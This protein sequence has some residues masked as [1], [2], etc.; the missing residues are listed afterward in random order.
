MSTIT[1]SRDVDG[2]KD[3]VTITLATSET[4]F[5]RRSVLIFV[6]VSPMAL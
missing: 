1:C 3:T 6:N 5:L 4:A 2:L